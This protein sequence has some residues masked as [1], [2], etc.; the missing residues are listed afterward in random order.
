MAAYNY[1][2]PGREMMAFD[3]IH[4]YA[5]RDRDQ[6]R[7]TPIGRIYV[8]Q[9][10]RRIATSCGTTS[11]CRG[12]NEIAFAQAEEQVDVAFVKGNGMFRKDSRWGTPEQCQR[13]L[14]CKFAHDIYRKLNPKF[15]QQ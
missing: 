2:L 5:K 14:D 8:A 11:H 7:L 12:T 1:T 6:R 4:N 3:Y 9:L 15:Q 10:R 13:F